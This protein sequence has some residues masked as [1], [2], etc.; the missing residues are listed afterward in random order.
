MKCLPFKAIVLIALATI[1]SPIQAQDTLT[2]A[3]PEE[4]LVSAIRPHKYPSLLWEVSGNGLKKPSYL[5]GTMHVSRKLVFRLTDSFFKAL[6]AADVVALESDANKWIDELAE[7]GYGRYNFY[8]NYQDY[9]YN[10]GFYNSAFKVGFPKKTLFEYLL[11][12]EEELADA[13]MYRKSDKSRNFS[14]EQF[15]DM[16]IHQAGM[17]LGKQVTG[18]EDY[19]V[20]RK[21]VAKSEIRDS[22]E[23]KKDKKRR[24]LDYYGENGI[25]EQL[26]NAYRMGDLDLLDSLETLMAPGK[27][28]L[29]WMLWER[30]KV[31]VHSFDS[32]VKTGKVLFAGVGSAHV[33]GD[34][35]VVEM[36]RR[37]GYSVRP[38]KGKANK[39][40][41][42]QKEQIDLM[43]YKQTYSQFQSPN[44][45]FKAQFP[46]IPLDYAQGTMQEYFYPDMA[47]G[48]YYSVTR[49]PYYGALSSQT[50][51]FVLSR[52]DSLLFE[53]IPGKIISKKDIVRNGYPGFD[54]EN[55]T[56]LGDYQRYMIIATPTYLWFAK[57]AGQNNYV[58][59]KNSDIFF[60]SFEIEEKAGNKWTTY[61]PPCGG[62]EISWPTQVLRLRGKRDTS[63]LLKGHIDL[64]AVDKQGN[65]YFL[66]N[67]ELNGND[68]FEEDS[69]ELSELAGSLYYDLKGK[70]LQ[71]EWITVNGQPGIQTRFYSQLAQGKMYLRLFIYGNQFY[72]AGCKSADETSA[73]QFLQSL[74]TVPYKYHKEMSWYT[75][76]LMMAKVKTVE[77]ENWGKP[78][79]DD[80]SGQYQFE[81]SGDDEDAEPKDS[82]HMGSLFNS[83]SYGY[84]TG[85][86][87]FVQRSI[88]SIFDKPIGLDSTLQEMR[89]YIKKSSIAITRL[90][91][92]SKEGWQYI[93]LVQTDTNSSRAAY[94][95]I[96][97]RDRDHYYLSC[98]YDTVSKLTPF[99]KAVMDNFEPMDSV[100]PYRIPRKQR[101]DSLLR[102]CLSADSFTQR[103]HRSLA[104]DYSDW[105]AADA[106]AIIRTL[107]KLNRQGKRNFESRLYSQLLRAL[108]NLHHPDVLPY[109]KK[110]FYKAGDTAE[111]QIQLLN[112]IS[113]IH[114]NEAG[115]IFT[116]LLLEETPLSN[117]EWETK[118]LLSNYM[119][120]LKYA[121]TLFPKLFELLRYNEYRS[122]V[123]TLAA[124]LLDSGWL[125]IAACEPYKNGLVMEF[126]DQWKREKASQTRTKKSWE[127]GGETDPDEKD[128]EEKY[129]TNT[130][131]KTSDKLNNI[132]KNSYRGDYEN[133]ASN[134]TEQYNGSELLA[135]ARIMIPWYNQPDVK[136]RMDK[137]LLPAKRPDLFEWTSFFLKHKLPVPD[138]VL[139]IFRKR[140]DY[141]WGLAEFNQLPDSVLLKIK[142]P[143]PKVESFIRYRN[144]GPADSLVFLGT[145]NIHSRK[146]S[147]T[148]YFYKHS[149]KNSYY[150]DEW[151]MDWVLLP[152]KETKEHW[153]APEWYRLNYDYDTQRKAEEQ[154]NDAVEILRKMDRK[155]WEPRNQGN[156]RRYR[157]RY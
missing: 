74:K 39:W 127:W 132:N 66:Q 5:Y 67:A 29:K 71:R 124:A 106:P 108:G 6:Y 44:G 122:Q 9:G 8:G 83:T 157:Y 32:I 57:M 72:L 61:S 37:L 14:E 87:V 20:S 63:H 131:E 59:G 3:A 156:S 118:G 113:E 152:E 30:N 62:Y 7:E 119:D 43:Q 24:R 4:T 153:T 103:I 18:L 64:H 77:L 41:G 49:L 88:S 150:S 69:F 48:A 26:E 126:R 27:N 73:L 85:E 147:G 140:S 136:R 96:M 84:T 95:K 102:G 45:D 104:M 35:G 19:K 154:M 109:L 128:N 120:T 155:R 93:E 28:F 16:F 91:T 138:S 97:R 21:M 121:K 115:R 34:S 111:L 60:N 141:Q 92:G 68:Y 116:D 82:L 79:E 86:S 133:N 110:Q 146:V 12:R 101:S 134:A 94:K 90:D 42:K 149:Y 53:N 81:Y 70:D 139:N 58:S 36:L 105:D 23:E 38:V 33:P 80:V 137:L 98:Y 50:P 78:K 31:M 143:K 89:K 46:G 117:S 112:Q 107:E 25:Y 55:R 76:S 129:G 47:N 11:Q 99:V 145:R 17:K 52:I 75:D 151:Y 56:S 22:K 148:L 130:Y 135:L 123:L 65:Y 1:Y 100:M 15:L 2:E 144:M 13:M 51:A 114:T 54:I 142:D 125:N 40:A 10:S